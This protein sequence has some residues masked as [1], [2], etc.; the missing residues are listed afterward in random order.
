MNIFKYI[1]FLL[2]FSPA[3]IAAPEIKGNPDELRGFLHP[4]ASIVSLSARA[5]EKAYTDKAIVSV[6]V[7][8]EDELL[9]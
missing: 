9:S 3:V 2:L 7:T 1:A 8:T 6:V 5:E 4:N